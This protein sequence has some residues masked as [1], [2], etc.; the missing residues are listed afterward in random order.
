MS[1]SLCK[2]LVSDGL[3]YTIT[4]ICRRVKLMRV[5]SCTIGWFKI[6]FLWCWEVFI[7]QCRDR[8]EGRERGR[9]VGRDFRPDLNPCRMWE[10]FSLYDTRSKEDFFFLNWQCEMEWERKWDITPSVS[11]SLYSMWGNNVMTWEEPGTQCLNRSLNR[12]LISVC[13]NHWKH[14]LQ[15]CSSTYKITY[16]LLERQYYY[17]YLN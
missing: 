15:V 8:K 7:G 12:F 16:P 3:G 6:I 11:F 5:L 14:T 4:W 2:V 1:A 10:G 13:Y 17:Y 9:R